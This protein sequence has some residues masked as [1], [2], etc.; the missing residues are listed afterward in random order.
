[1][2]SVSKTSQQISGNLNWPYEIKPTTDDCIEVKVVIRERR[3]YL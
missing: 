1:M 3:D 2:I